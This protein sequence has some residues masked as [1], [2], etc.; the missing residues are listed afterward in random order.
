MTARTESVARS[1]LDTKVI[2]LIFIVLDAKDEKKDRIIAE[3]VTK[4]HR[5]ISN[6]KENYN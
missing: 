6:Y 4:N 2:D 5:Y 1:I 3:R